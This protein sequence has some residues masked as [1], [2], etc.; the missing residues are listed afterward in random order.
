[1]LPFAARAAF[2]VGVEMRKAG[3]FADGDGVRRRSVAGAVPETE[4][5]AGKVVGFGDSVDGS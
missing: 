1:M 3:D 2:S 5:E 4:D